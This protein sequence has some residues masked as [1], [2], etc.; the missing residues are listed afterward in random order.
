M[1]PRPHW[2]DFVKE[3]GFSVVAPIKVIVP[4]PEVRQEG[5]LLSL[6]GHPTNSRGASRRR[7]ARSALPPPPERQPLAARM[8]PRTLDELVGQEHL[9]GERG[10]LRRS[11]ARGH[12]SSLLPRPMVRGSGRS[13]A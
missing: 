9:A 5:V 11:V 10:P 4:S 6:R 8:R 1:S 2:T 13:E 12:L 3:Y 7:P